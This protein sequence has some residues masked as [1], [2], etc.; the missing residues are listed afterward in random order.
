MYQIQKYT[1][2][3]GIAC[4]VRLLWTPWLLL[5]H[6]LAIRQA[7]TVREIKGKDILDKKSFCK[8]ARCM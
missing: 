2:T 5:R 7:M 4:F 6:T 3:Q 1:H 8:D